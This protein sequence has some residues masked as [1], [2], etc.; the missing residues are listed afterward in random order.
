MSEYTYHR[1]IP[2]P[3]SFPEAPFAVINAHKHYWMTSHRQPGEKEAQAERLSRINAIIHDFCGEYVS[4]SVYHAAILMPLMDKFTDEIRSR[5]VMRSLKTFKDQSIAGE[6]ADIYTFGLL[7]NRHVIA[8]FWDSQRKDISHKAEEKG[9]PGVVDALSPERAGEPVDTL[10]WLYTPE[11]TLLEPMQVFLREEVDIESLIIQA[12]ELLEWLE[13]DRAGNTGETLSYIYAAESLFAPLSEIIGLD[14]LASALLNACTRLRYTNAGQ[15]VY[16]D[17]AA[18]VLEPPAYTDQLDESVQAI[19]EAALGETLYDT[20]LKNKSNHGIVIG[21]GF[22][23]DDVR[24]IWRLKSQGSLARKLQKDGIGNVPLD[25]IGATAILPDLELT[26]ARF[27]SM[28]AAVKEHPSLSLTP[29]PT[30]QQSTHV[31]GTPEH[32]E[33]FRIA[34]GYDS[35]EDMER[36]IDVVDITEKEGGSTKVTPYQVA[37][38]TLVY[39]SPSGEKVNVEIQFNTEQDRIEARTGSAAHIAIKYLLEGQELNTDILKWVNAQKHQMKERELK[40]ASHARALR[41]M[42]A[43]DATQYA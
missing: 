12:A 22:T 7:A 17:R 36:D 8:E 31:R 15:S 25:I 43:I 11:L 16:L 18:Q 42:Q 35:R 41:L 33:A 13:S 32:I 6:E 19:F 29:S 38:A 10:A 30:R 34:C 4:D 39:T 37:K 3:E 27:A 5:N 1:D 20:V 2:L 40:P 28:L 23:H 9:L 14:G 21:E 24:L 26:A